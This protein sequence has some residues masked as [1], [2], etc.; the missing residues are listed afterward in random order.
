MHRAA[1]GVDRR[2]ATQPRLHG[3]RQPIVCGAEVCKACVASP[4]RR[5]DDMIYDVAEYLAAKG[6]GGERES[7]REQKARPSTKQGRRMSG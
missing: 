2:T 4:D 5:L 6:A 7:V 1:V 3:R